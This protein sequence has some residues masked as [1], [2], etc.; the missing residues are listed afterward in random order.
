[1]ASREHGD[2]PDHEFD[3]GKE[4]RDY[5]DPRSDPSPGLEFGELK[6]GQSRSQPIRVG[7]GILLLVVVVIVLI[8]VL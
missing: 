2:R 6:R 4:P 8:V 7:I 3:P 5:T 1:M